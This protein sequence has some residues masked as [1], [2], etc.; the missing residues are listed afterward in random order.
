MEGGGGG[1]GGGSEA[2]Q[3]FRRGTASQLL[4]IAVRLRLRR[5]LISA[6]DR[7]SYRSQKLLLLA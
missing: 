5:R 1:V 4:L 6:R 2:E 7:R 3:G